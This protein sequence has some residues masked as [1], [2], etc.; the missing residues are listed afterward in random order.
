MT[1]FAYGF[2][3]RASA[4]KF[5]KAQL[6]EALYKQAQ[7][8]STAIPTLPRVRQALTSIGAGLRNGLGKLPP[9][10]TRIGI[11]L[12]GNKVPRSPGINPG[13]LPEPMPGL[14]NTP[15][16]YRDNFDAI[17]RR[18]GGQPSTE[19]TPSKTSPAGS[20]ADTPASP[21]DGVLDY[22]RRRKYQPY[23]PNRLE[24]MT[25]Y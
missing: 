2:I 17:R 14:A 25:R 8:V 12:P 1:P 13:Q 21:W 19:N 10:A 22:Y 9:N 4:R 15:F 24:W 7:Q 16:G 11:N 6:L 20:P 3:K 5:N 18:L 23:D